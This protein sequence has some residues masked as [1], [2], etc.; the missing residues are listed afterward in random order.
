MLRLATI[1]LMLVLGFLVLFAAHHA[2][3]TQGETSHVVLAEIDN[4]SQP[5][6]GNDASP[7]IA[8]ENL[9]VG[10]ATGC[11]V[12]TVCCALGLALQSVRAW[13]SDL[14]RRLNSVA[15]TVRAITGVSPTALLSAARPSLVALSISRT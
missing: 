15:K 6:A 9:A 14:F 1:I 10:L 12:L 2:Q 3:T 7:D 13:R 11:I 8:D 5:L 4:A